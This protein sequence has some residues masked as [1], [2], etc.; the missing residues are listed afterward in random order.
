[1][2]EATGFAP[3]ELMYGRVV[4][5]PSQLLYQAWTG[6]A[7]EEEI[8]SM[9]QYVQ[10]M[11]QTMEEMVKQAQDAVQASA[12][13]NRTRKMVTAKARIFSAGQMVNVLIP[14][15]HK[16]M[17]WQWKGPYSRRSSRSTI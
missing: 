16:K 17:L 1:M 6:P 2:N 14:D 11:K 15:V 9:P 13:K 7:V 5:G 12:Q 4:K 3:F 10:E 8:K